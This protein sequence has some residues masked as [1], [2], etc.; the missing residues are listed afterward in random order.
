M[1]RW[2]WLCSWFP[3]HAE[4]PGTASELQR[5]IALDLANLSKYLDVFDPHPSGR[6]AALSTESYATAQKQ[7][8][9][10]KGLLK[11]LASGYRRYQ[12]RS[13]RVLFRDESLADAWGELQEAISQLF[14]LVDKTA[15]RITLG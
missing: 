14:D 7:V 12:S 1:R 11:G 13:Y 6:P 3:C 15:R 10:L 2:G 5:V 9:A 8:D 4:E